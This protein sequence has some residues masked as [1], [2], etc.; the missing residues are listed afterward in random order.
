M[1]RALRRTLVIAGVLVFADAFVLNQGVIALVTALGGLIGGVP[2]AL[3]AWRSGKPTTARLRAARLF[4]S[5]TLSVTTGRSSQIHPS[6]SAQRAPTR[7]AQV[8]AVEGYQVQNRLA[9]RVGR[10]ASGSARP[11]RDDR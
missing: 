1:W 2:R 8:Q 11:G 4:H 3:L 6:P 7:E 9:S 5:S 10:T